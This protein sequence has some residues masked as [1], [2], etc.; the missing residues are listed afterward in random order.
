M[1]NNR[2]VVLIDSDDVLG[3]CNK[4]MAE[5]VYRLFGLQYAE[6]DVH[7]W[8]FFKS[9]EERHPEH[10]TL[11]KDVEAL[12]RSRG[13]AASMDVFDGAREGVEK[14]RTIAEVFIAT[15]PFGGEFWEYERRQWLWDNFKVPGKRVMQGHSKFL[16]HAEAFV[17][18][19][20]ANITLWAEYNK[21]HAR[22]PGLSLLWDR[23]HNRRENLDRVVSWDDLYN[24]V[25]R[26]YYP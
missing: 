10:P 3:R 21:G 22:T 19:K 13:W 2:P 1:L 9:L 16:L 14:L 18:D 20:P 12:M 24:R 17:D 15:S 23:P 25:Y 8:D 11:K 4:K 5:E 7:E 26:E 6:E